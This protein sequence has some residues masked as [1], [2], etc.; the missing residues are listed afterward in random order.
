MKEK[1][2]KIWTDPVLSK[3][4]SFG[5]IGLITLLINALKSYSNQ[6]DFQT[7]FLT[8][9][10]LEIKLWIVSLFLFLIYISFLFT[11]RKK[12]GFTYD[13]ETLELDK[14]FFEK[15]RTE[16]F[17]QNAVLNLKNNTFSSCPIETSEFD[18][19]GNTLRLFDNPNSEFLNPKLEELKIKLTNSL[20]NLDENLR[21]SLFGNGHYTGEDIIVSL[22]KEWEYERYMAKQKEM[23]DAENETFN[24]FEQLVKESRRV[25][26]I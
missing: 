13:K 4:I 20:E 17:N 19:V 1:F 26:K 24:N 8:F 15:I 16:L 22:P 11:K 25:L 23:R 21:N 14:K 12:K 5:L 7:E 3:I 18:F 9:W 10:N 6:T 2:K